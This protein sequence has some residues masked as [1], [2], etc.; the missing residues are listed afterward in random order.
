MLAETDKKI[1]L[2]FSLS[3]PNGLDS[4]LALPILYASQA[5]LRTVLGE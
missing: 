4:L 1:A 5:V 3:R 2:H